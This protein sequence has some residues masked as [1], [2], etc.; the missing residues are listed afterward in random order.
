[1]SRL[2]DFIFESLGPSDQFNK[3][4]RMNENDG[5]DFDLNILILTTESESNKGG[6]Y[7]T[8]KRL[9][10]E[11][12]H[13]GIPSY[14]LFSDKA[15]LEL[16]DDNNYT[17]HNLDD[18]KGFPIYS[19]KTVAINRGSV[20]EKS[21]SRN[22]ISQLERR[23]I[24]C[25]NNRETIETCF[26]KYRTMLKI[27]DAGVPT[28]K[29]VL[30]QGENGIDDAV[31]TLG[32]KFPYIVKTLHGSKGIG[33][34]FVE[35]M[36]ALT[37]M[38]QLIWK[39][40]EDTEMILQEYIPV[41]F[42]IRVHVLGDEVIGAMKRYVVKDDFR[43]NYSQGGKVENYKPSD[44]EKEICIRASKAVG[45][46][47][48]GVDYL[49]RN[50]E[51][52]VIEVNASPGTEGIEKATKTNI[53]GEILEWAGDKDNWNK[54]A[55]EIGYK[56]MVNVNGLDLVA[57]FDTGNGVFCVIHA[58]KYTIDKEKKMV[59]W[60]SHGKKF[61]NKYKEM[62]K[63]EVGGAKQYFEERPRIILDMFFDGMLYKDVG[64][65][66]DDRSDRTPILIDRTFMERANV[67]VNP[68][69]QFVIT[70]KEIS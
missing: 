68:A 61:E 50:N 39:V 29:T 42:D 5:K 55:K 46:S 51:P 19:D 59:K 6:L 62:E 58:D 10:K 65:T 9:S 41:D 28:P 22:I 25:I 56:E 16:D 13:M 38:L 3:I 57:K 34:I 30:I 54:V 36:P 17:A 49:I 40:N 7:Q 4:K 66:I 20:M 24:F 48:S 11:C 64:F 2:N 12:K 63:V 37:S 15:K 47:W 33:V 52:F 70:V 43:S 23:S 8:A 26:D 44:E 53:V 14:I 18:N 31:K 35:S 69:K 21:N 32:G 45:A 67:S 60:T 1:M 27:A